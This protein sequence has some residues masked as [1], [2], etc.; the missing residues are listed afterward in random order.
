MIITY[1]VQCS[2]CTNVIWQRYTPKPTNTSDVRTV[3][4]AIWADLPRCPI[5]AASNTAVP[6][7]APGV[8]RSGSGHFEHVV[9]IDV[10]SISVSCFFIII[11]MVSISCNC[12]DQ[13][14]FTYKMALCISHSRSVVCGC[15]RPVLTRRHSQSTNPRCIAAKS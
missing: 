1:G 12:T 2:I 15:S 9:W 3:L 4:Q 5:N 11:K 13:F 10:T 6:Q 7:K 14:L 8:H